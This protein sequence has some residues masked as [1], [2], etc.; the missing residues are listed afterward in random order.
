LL[1]ALCAQKEVTDFD[2][3]RRF[4][5]LDPHFCELTKREQ[6]AALLCGITT[7]NSTAML[8]LSALLFLA[9]AAAAAGTGKFLSQQLVACLK[10]YQLPSNMLLCCLQTLSTAIQ[11]LKL[12]LCSAA[13]MQMHFVVVYY[14]T[15]S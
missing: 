2:L 9:A 14:T 13:A 6:R 15:Y 5:R 7:I 8:R 1:H 11:Q 10:S 12:L 4:G 3:Q